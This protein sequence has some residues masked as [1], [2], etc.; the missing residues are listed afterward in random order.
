MMLKEKSNKWARLRLLLTL[1]LA[2]LSVYAFARHE[3][4]EPL[5]SLV[6]YESMNNFQKKKQVPPP[7]PPL[8]AEKQ[9]GD[10]K[11]PPPPPFPAEKDKKASSLTG[12]YTTVAISEIISEEA[13]GTKSV[14]VTITQ[15]NGIVKSYPIQINSTG[16]KKFKELK[17]PVVRIIPKRGEHGVSGT[18]EKIPDEGKRVY[19]IHNPPGKYDIVVDFQGVNEEGT[20]GPV[21]LILPP[22]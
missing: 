16:N 10:K 11:A 18:V 7:P 6:N 2:I 9:K 5:H 13:D 8:P 22:N 15:P 17:D 4:N 19:A 14:T 3:V 21:L 1:P 12:K 20:V